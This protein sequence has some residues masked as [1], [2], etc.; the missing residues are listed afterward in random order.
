MSAAGSQIA[1]YVKGLVGA[2]IG[3]AVGGFLFVL[4]IKQGFYML[5]LPGAAIGL[6]CGWLSRIRS[7]PLGVVCGLLAAGLSIGLE[8]SQRPFTADGSLGYFVSH[9]HQLTTVTQI[10]MVIGIA[11]AF[12]FGMGREHRTL[13]DAK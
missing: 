1:G 9:L 6:G 5:A 7:I 10:M 13:R 12:W 11:F 2:L 4:A 3:A 8:W